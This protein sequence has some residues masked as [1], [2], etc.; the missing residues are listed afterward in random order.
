MPIEPWKSEWKKERR[1]NDK[2]TEKL[3]D[4]NKFINV[5]T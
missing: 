4:T 2:G 1:R 5:L 3:E